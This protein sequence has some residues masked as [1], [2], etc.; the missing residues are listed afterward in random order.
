MTDADHSPLDLLDLPDLQREIVL[1]LTRSGLA[2]ADTLAQASGRD[3]AEVQN[4]LAEEGRVRLSA[5][6]QADVALGRVKSRTTLPARLWH[7]LL[8]MDRLYSDLRSLLHPQ[9]FYYRKVG[10]TKCEFQGL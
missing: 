5:G 4:A 3:L 1:Y 9:R 7:A 8:A 10:E 6:G 2:D